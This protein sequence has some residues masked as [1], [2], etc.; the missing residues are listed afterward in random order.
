MD[1]R[2]G[3]SETKAALL[4]LGATAPQKRS[5]AFE[6]D[7]HVLLLAYDEEEKSTTV[8]VGGPRAVETARW[9]ADQLE[10]TG[11]HVDGLPPPQVRR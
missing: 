10:E 2:A 3:L 5:V 11:R 7:E 8:A 6:L 1:V 4:A 9:L